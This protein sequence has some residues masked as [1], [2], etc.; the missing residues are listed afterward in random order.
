[1]ILILYNHYCRAAGRAFAKALDEWGFFN[2]PGDKVRQAKKIIRWGYWEDL[3]TNAKQINS[4]DGILAASNKLQALKTFK[5]NGIEVPEIF[6]DLPKDKNGIYLGRSRYHTGGTDIKVFR[7]GK[8]NRANQSEYFTKYINP[9]REWRVHVFGGKVLFVQKKFFASGKKDD[10]G[11][12]IRKT[13]ISHIVR[14]YD[15]GWR[16]YR[17]KDKSNC[18]QSVRDS[19]V[20]A[21]KCLSLM[22][23]AVDVISYGRDRNGNRKAC[24]LEVNTAPGLDEGVGMDDYV[25]EFKKW[26]YT[27]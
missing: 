14:S 9:H 5:K 6:D 27:K 16:F 23:G 15:N 20:K 22:F 8:R 26:L 7:D 4:Q 12:V 11:K 25:R 1:M 18:P 13:E 2:P 10:D 3:D 17:L 24:V 21:V 19:A